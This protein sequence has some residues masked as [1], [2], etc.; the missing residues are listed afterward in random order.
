[1]VKLKG[2]ILSFGAGGTIAGTLTVQQSKGRIYMRK[3]PVPI[4][5]NSGKQLSVRAMFKWLTKR[6]N[7][8]DAT[9]KESWAPEAATSLITPFDLYMKTNLLRWADFTY[10]I[11]NKDVEG[12]GTRQTAPLQPIDNR[13]YGLL[14]PILIIVVNDG[15]AQ[16]LFRSQTPAFTASFSNMVHVIDLPA[17]GDI[18]FLDSPLDPGTYYYRTQG[19]NDQGR[20]TVMGSIESAT[21]T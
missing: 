8:N 15:I 1:M 3:K 13:A 5:P 2:P 19:F 14:I 18:E 11:M 12:G 20:A 17:S 16:A 10:P 21:V 6:W 4:Q 9:Q 7:L